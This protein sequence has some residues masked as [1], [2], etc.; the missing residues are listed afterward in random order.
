MDQQNGIY[1]YTHKG[2]VFNLKRKGILIYV[3]GEM[4]LEDIML[5]EIGHSQRDK[6]GMIQPR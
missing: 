2:I 6:Y 4:N 1:I 3:T 5:S